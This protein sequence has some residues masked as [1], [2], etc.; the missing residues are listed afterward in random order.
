MVF[1]SLPPSLQQTVIR[2]EVLKNKGEPDPSSHGWSPPASLQ[3]GDI[4][5][6]TPCFWNPNCGS[7][8]E[9]GKLDVGA[10]GS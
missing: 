3:E 5:R 6:L 8:V 4:Q 7:S 2:V 1:P 10:G 9:E